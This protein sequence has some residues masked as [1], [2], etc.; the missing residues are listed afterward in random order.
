[1]HQEKVILSY[2]FLQQPFF[3]DGLKPCI[4]QV[5]D[6]FD[7]FIPSSFTSE[8]LWANHQRQNELNLS[9]LNEFLNPC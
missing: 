8:F 1:M 5:F 2:Q 7:V 3:Y 4:V 9:N 6:K